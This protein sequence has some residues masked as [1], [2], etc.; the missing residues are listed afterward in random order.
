MVFDDQGAAGY[1]ARLYYLT[2]RGW[3][4]PLPPD[5]EAVPP[6]RSR[7]RGPALVRS[8]LRDEPPSWLLNRR[9]PEPWRLRR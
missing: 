6:E 8:A 9:E 2:A 1:R 4:P 7:S 5:I 3:S